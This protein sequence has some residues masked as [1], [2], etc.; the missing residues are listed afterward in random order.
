MQNAIGLLAGLAIAATFGVSAAVAGSMPSHLRLETALY[1]DHRAEAK[2][3]RID[4]DDDDDDDEGVRHRPRIIERHY[5]VPYETYGRSAYRR[6]PSYGR[7]AYGRPGRGC[8]VVVTRRFNQF[9]ERIVT[10]QRICRY[11]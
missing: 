3:L 2:V 6:R 1:Q 8:R 5:I 11:V 10:R 7:P 9:G 4:D